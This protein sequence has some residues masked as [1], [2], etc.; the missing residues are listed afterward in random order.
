MPL[1]QIFTFFW[2]LSSF[3]EMIHLYVSRDCF[4]IVRTCW[5]GPWPMVSNWFYCRPVCAGSQ[6][7]LYHVGAASRVF[8][9]GQGLHVCRCPFSCVCVVGGGMDQWEGHALWNQPACLSSG[10]PS[11]M[12]F[13]VKWRQSV[14]KVYNFCEEPD[15]K[16][17]GFYS[18][19]VKSLGKTQ[20]T[21]N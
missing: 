13:C 2:N 9:L 14:L 21:S 17:F 15:R 1:I 4:L 6:M 19:R 3:Q 20:G 5:P 7:W 10:S 18:S 16:Y 12:F 11:F 8:S